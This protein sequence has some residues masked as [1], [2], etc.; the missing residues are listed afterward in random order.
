MAHP[1]RH[2]ASAVRSWSRRKRVSAGERR[3]FSE[4]SAG[5]LSRR[6]RDARRILQEDWGFFRPRKANAG[7]LTAILTDNAVIYLFTSS[8][9]F[10]LQL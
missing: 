7:R 3:P 5:R 9:V 10:F 6:R 2:R 8:Y 1:R 4:K